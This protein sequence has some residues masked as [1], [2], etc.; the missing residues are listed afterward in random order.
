MATEQIIDYERK[1]GRSRD[2]QLAD[3]LVKKSSPQKELARMRLVVVLPPVQM[4]D[5]EVSI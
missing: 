1:D 4:T 3:L 5:R 2:N